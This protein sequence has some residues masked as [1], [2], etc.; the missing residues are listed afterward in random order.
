MSARVKRYG[1]DATDS[2]AVG[3]CHMCGWRALAGD[4]LGAA[5]LI[6]DHELR[7]HPGEHAGA[8]MLARYGG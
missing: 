1:I 3:M 8:M 7:A 4:R 2:S 6:R 5:R